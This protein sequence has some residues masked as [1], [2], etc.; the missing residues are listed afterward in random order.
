MEHISKHIKRF[1][2]NFEE[3]GRCDRMV[4]KDLLEYASDYSNDTFVLCEDYW[5][6]WMYTLMNE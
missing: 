4:R 1:E 6:C 2:D 5:E 3:C